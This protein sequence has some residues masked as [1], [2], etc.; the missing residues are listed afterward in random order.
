MLILAVVQKEG[1]HSE[2]I[3]ETLRSSHMQ[4]QGPQ[5]RSVD[6]T[7][8]ALYLTLST[9]HNAATTQLHTD[10]ALIILEQVLFFCVTHLFFRELLYLGQT[11]KDGGGDTCVWR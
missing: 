4:M 1:G 5:R 11:W 10:A 8:K 9:T 7:T 3:T 6:N 2:E